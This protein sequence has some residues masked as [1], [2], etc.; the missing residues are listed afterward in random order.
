MS[1]ARRA[2]QAYEQVARRYRD[3]AQQLLANHISSDELLHALA[4]ADEQLVQAPA[5]TDCQQDDEHSLTAAAVA[6]THCQEAHAVLLQVMRGIS[7]TYQKEATQQRRHTRALNAYRHMRGP[8]DPRFL[9]R[10]Q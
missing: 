2:Q 7:L 4:Q 3:L 8:V 5:W 6:A 1:L 10:A 9:D